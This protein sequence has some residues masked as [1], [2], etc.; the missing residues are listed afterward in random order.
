[1]EYYFSVENLCKDIFLRSKMD[2]NGW[3]SLAVIGA[4]NRVR[5]LAPDPLLIVEALKDSTIVRTRPPGRAQRPPLS[6]GAGILICDWG[7]GCGLQVEFQ[8]DNSAL[9]KR[10]DWQSWLLPEALKPKDKGKDGADKADKADKAEAK[11]DAKAEKAEKE[12][13]KPPPAPVPATGK[14]AGPTTPAAVDAAPAGKAPRS[15]AK[16]DGVLPSSS[17]SG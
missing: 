7:V 14:G 15:K 3:I 10:E 1:M 2:A 8:G 11:A 9:R 4:F 13:G 17:L 6:S 12:K 5:M 16:K